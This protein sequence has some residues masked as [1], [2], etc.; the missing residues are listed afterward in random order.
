MSATIYGVTPVSAPLE[1]G[2]QEPDANLD[3]SL[4]I[5]ADINA[6]GDTVATAQASASPSGP[7]ELVVAD[8]TIT[9]STVPI[10]NSSATTIR[11]L[12]TVWLSG[13]IAGR[14]YLVKIEATAAVTPSGAPA[15]RKFEWLAQFSI[16]S[17]L[18]SVPLPGVSNPGFGAPTLWPAP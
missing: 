10:P 4:D 3:Y 2:R 12:A 5:S 18:A 14:R 9:Q 15:P 1:L 13:G 17:T 11:W 6:G 16:G 7:G 8:L